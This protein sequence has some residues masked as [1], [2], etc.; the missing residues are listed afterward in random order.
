LV[1]LESAD[2]PEPL[3]A[4][5]KWYGQII[6]T[7]KGQAGFGYDPLFFVPEL[8]KTA[9]ELSAEEKNSVSHRSTAL[10]KLLLELQERISPPSC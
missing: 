4:V 10:K 1:Y 5:G 7:P 6:E 9:A 8:G 3:I 2:D